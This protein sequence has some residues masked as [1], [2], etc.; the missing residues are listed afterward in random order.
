MKPNKLFDAILLGMLWCV[1]LP[2]AAA[3]PKAD[4]VVPVLQPM[5]YHGHG[6]S[7]CTIDP[8]KEEMRLFYA[9]DS[10]NP[11]HDFP[12][13]DTYVKAHGGKLLFAANAGMFEPD[14]HPVGLL[15]MNS[16]QVSP[17]N[18]KDGTGNF[19]MKPNGVFEINEKAEAHIVESSEYAGFVT[20]PVWATQSGPLM[21][22]GGNIHPDLNAD[23]KS[24]KIRSGVGVRKDGVVVF[25]LSTGPVN[26]YDFAVLFLNKL[27][28]PNALYLDGDISAF[29][30][31]DGKPQVG[32]SFG[33][34]LGV[35][36]GMH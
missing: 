29:W 18:L 13:M 4:E 31:P 28:C 22:Y 6:Y 2:L 32:H 5:T 10:G 23:S 27:K 20:P 30:V 9:D 33:P 36:E 14:S 7:V 8:K 19:Y 26:F 1:V 12:A 35:A 11:L 15:L 21:V 25:A 34:I 16:N 17:L 3:P 24:L